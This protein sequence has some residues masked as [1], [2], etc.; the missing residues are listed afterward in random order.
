MISNGP[1]KI[2]ER[3]EKYKNPW[4]EIFEDQVIRPDGTPGI[5]G[6]VNLQSGATTICVDSEGYTYLGK[7]FFYALGRYEL[8][9]ATGARDKNED[10]LTCAKRELEEELGISADKWTDFGDFNPLTTVVK[11]PM[12]L[13]LAEDLTLK[14]QH[15]E[16]TEDITRVKIKLSEAV[17]KIGSEITAGPTCTALIKA[18][19]HLKERK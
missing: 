2:K 12:R 1:W 10:Y 9:C 5:H 15:L 13:F 7:E 18:Y 14:E 4:M 17:K 19:L 16:G 8:V 6:V 3:V 11:A